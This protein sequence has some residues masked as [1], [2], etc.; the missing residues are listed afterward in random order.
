MHRLLTAASLTALL[1][2]AACDEPRPES[3]DAVE[4]QPEVV[5]PAAEDSAAPVVETAPPPVETP[6]TDALPPESR[7]S[8]ETVQPDS[9]TLFY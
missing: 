7:T 3:Y 9:E 5:A 1:A 4:T 8:E 2:L 6:P